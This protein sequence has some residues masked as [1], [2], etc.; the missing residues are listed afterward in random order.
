MLRVIS[1]GAGVQSTAMV[2][3]ALD[4]EFGDMPDAAIF[5]D[6]GW[7][8]EA[9]YKHLEWLEQEIAGRIPLYRVSAGNLKEDV[10]RAKREN[11]SLYVSLPLYTTSDHGGQGILR[12]QCTREYKIGPILRK[13]RELLGLKPRQ[14]PQG[15]VLE[16]WI[17]ISLDEAQRMKS[18]FEAW[19]VHR[20]PLIERRLTRHDCLLWLEKHGYPRPPKSA[21]VGCPFHDNGYWRTMRDTQ[22]IEWA[23]AVEFDRTIRELPKVRAKNYVHPSRVPLDQVDLTTPKDHGQLDFTDEC[24]G[25]CGV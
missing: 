19:K 21:C 22:P 13:E 15:I 20:Y 24:E 11:H 4:G 18:S 3:M 16:Q 5:A 6:T 1:L 23:Q 12:R 8:P 7:E 17:G 2:L 10:E 25:M 14:K 9:V